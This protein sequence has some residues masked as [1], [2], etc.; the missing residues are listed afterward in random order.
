MLLV[1]LVVIYAIGAGVVMI[2]FRDLW[3]DL[4]H[5]G[6]QAE[7]L[8]SQRNDVWD[9]VTVFRGFLSLGA[10]IVLLML[11]LNAQANENARLSKAAT[12]TAQHRAALDRIDARLKPFLIEWRDLATEQLRYARL[13]DLHVFYGRCPDRAD[14]YA[15]VYDPVISGRFVGLFVI[16]AY[17]YGEGGMPRCVSSIL[18]TTGEFRRLRAN[19]FIVP[20]VRKHADLFTP[21]PT[22]APTRTPTLVF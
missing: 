14:F 17:V 19:W 3:W 1:W 2:F 13:D 9:A 15:I 20:A 10:G 18:K 6:N 12:V 7:G 22:Q 21:T 16:E 5:L 4:T 11:A 8:A